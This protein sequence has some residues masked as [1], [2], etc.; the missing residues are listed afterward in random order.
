VV[1]FTPR[2]H[3]I[4]GERTPGTHIHYNK[5]ISKSDNKV[6]TVWKIVKDETGKH[7]T[8]EENPSIKVN[9]S[10]INSPKLTANS[11]NTYFLTIVEKPNN[12][13]KSPTEEEA[14]QYMTKTISR[15]FQDINLLLTMANEVKN[16]I[17]SLKSEN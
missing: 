3:F 1:I 8:V 11:V 10:V 16:I 12:G 15:T 14:I 5:Q 9:N 4:S 17:N 7:L 6:R 2:L 13:T